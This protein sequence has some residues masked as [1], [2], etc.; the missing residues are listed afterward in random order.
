MKSIVIGLVG[1]MVLSGGRAKADFTFGEPV[2]LG[3]SVNT[4]AHECFSTISSDGLELYFFD[5]DF[6]RPGG[7]GGMD[8]WV[9][10]RSSV[11]E[12]WSEPVNLG[13]PINS[14]YDDA[15]PSLSQDGLTLYFSSNRPGG[16]GAF[17]LW[18]CTRATVTDPWGEP[19]NLGQPVNSEYDEI[20]PC[21]SPDGLELY[22]NEWGVFRPEGY[23]DSDIYVAKRATTDDPWGEPVNIGEAA[24]SPYYDSCP[25]LSPDG[26]L[27]FL[28]GWRPGG[29][30][31]EDMWVSTR[32]STSD[33]WGTPVSL[34]TPINS[35]QIDGCPGVSADG[36]TFYFASMRGGG[37]GIGDTWQAAIIPVVDFN[38][39]GRVNDQDR[40]HRHHRCR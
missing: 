33:A 25:Y 24:N 21:V 14:E 19:A 12:P 35:R 9:T 34:P 29:P 15:K 23:G 2:N 11:S 28:H 17:D 5:L 3:P 13:A 4:A 39:D 1:A 31:P 7:L 40:W 27:L 30:G 20:F 36:S 10:R 22:F 16:Y 8:M 38:G 32:S 18:M 6:L 37:S 26:L